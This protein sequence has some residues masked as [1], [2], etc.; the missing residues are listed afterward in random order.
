MKAM[1]DRIAEIY[2]LTDNILK[3]LNH[4]EDTRCSLSDAEITTA[5]GC[6]GIFF[7]GN[8]EKSCAMLGSPKYKD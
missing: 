8:F 2:C 6:A 3:S 1:K 7:G 4:Y 5:A